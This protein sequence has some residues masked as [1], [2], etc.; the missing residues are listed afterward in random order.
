MA[1]PRFR[2]NKKKSDQDDPDKGRKL[3]RQ[4]LKEAMAMLRYIRPYRWIYILGIVFLVFSTAASL[5][6]PYITGQLVNSATGEDSWWLTEIDQ[7]AVLLLMI[8]IGQGIFS[9]FRIYTFNYVAEMGIA[10]ARRDLFRKLVSLPMAFFEQRRVGELTSRITADL[11]QMQNL[12][13]LSL[14]EFFRQISTLIGGIIALLIISPELTLF[15]LSVFPPI[16]IVTIF[17]GRFIRKLS[18][19]SQDELANSNA[20]VEESLQNISI[21]KAFVNELFQFGRYS[22]AVKK[23]VRYRLKYTTWRAG[24][25]S[26]IIFALFGSIV[27]VIWR[28]SH[29]V[30]EDNLGVGSLVSFIMY[31]I[32]I[33][34]SLGGL[35]DI[36]TQ[37]I[38]TVGA[39]E[40]SREILAQDSEVDLQ[41]PQGLH[42]MP[43]NGDVRF[44]GVKF[45]YPTRPD[46]EVLHGIDLSLDSGQKIA[47]AGSSGAGKSTIVQLLMRFYEISGGGITID[48]RNLHEYDIRF[49]RSKMGVVPQEVILFGGTIREN[50]S[51]GKP[52][53]SEEEIKAAAQKANAWN[54]IDSFPEKLET[55]V[56]ERGVKLSGGQR[57]RIAIARAILK[58]PAILILDEAT[59]S[60]DAESEKLVQDALD[61]LME[62]RSTIIIAH[63]LAT[64]RNVDRIYVLDDGQIAESGTHDELVD[65]EGGIYQKLIQLQMH[66]GESKTV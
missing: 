36:Y 3:T 6:F 59:S 27:L 52:E 7:I 5:A 23:V 15:M 17:F 37:I 24:F 51:Y 40:R 18:K 33:G 1:A 14:A 47:L 57:Q 43:V 56:G 66:A 35:P 39:T 12:L 49:I 9:F 38:K 34:G 29:M 31:T 11:D 32:F 63:R 53:A 10:D 44:E 13:S 45:S 22:E 28:G 21:V 16:I 50:I 20:E 8:L 26:F 25:V 61:K 41:T 62:G 54:F 65:K 30:L 64:I 55:V 19:L 2:R 60:L 46:T 58:D 4:G 48:G 42:D